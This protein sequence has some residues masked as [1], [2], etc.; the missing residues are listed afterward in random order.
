MTQ[1]VCRALVSLQLQQRYPQP[2]LIQLFDA[3]D[4]NLSGSISIYALTVLLQRVKTRDAARDDVSVA[5]LMDRL[6][7]RR[8]DLR[9]KLLVDGL[10]ALE[11]REPT[12]LDELARTYE[13]M[14]VGR[15]GSLMPGEIVRYAR[16][17]VVV[18]PRVS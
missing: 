17:A 12:V 4:R 6:F 16:N 3:L 1:L 10:K 18:P 14:D 2:K 9:D 5:S 11:R 15:T 8:P 7:H 13:N